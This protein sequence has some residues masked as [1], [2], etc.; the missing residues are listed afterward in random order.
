[1]IQSA[2]A[3]SATGPKP[4]PFDRLP[5]AGTEIIV[6]DLE[7]TGLTPKPEKPGDPPPPDGFD[8]LVEISAV[9]YRDGRVLDRFYVMVKPNKP[10]PQEV[11]DITH[12][13]N[14]MAQA[15]GVPTEAALPRFFAFIGENPILVGHNAKWFDTKF[16][17][18]VCERYGFPELKEKLQY[19]HVV[20]TKI[21]SQKLFPDTKWTKDENGNKVAPTPGP[22]SPANNK[23]TTLAAFLGINNEGAHR[24]E[25][26]VEMCA[27]VFYK[28]VERIQEK[29][30]RMETFGDVYAYMFTPPK[31]RNRKK[32]D[33]G[34]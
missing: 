2:K 6:F 17:R 11:I 32:S 9:K 8:D 30:T 3:P 22:D 26:D 14:E 20:D 21:M 31:P 1:V 33:P 16:M 25:N 29:G 10:I 13:T 7:T 5:I 18:A 34:T 4:T 24:A 28:L 19:D 27:Q 23:L 12:I 15:E